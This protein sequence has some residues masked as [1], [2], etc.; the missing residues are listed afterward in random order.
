MFGVGLGLAL[1]LLLEWRDTSLKTDEDVK[2]AL[3]LPVLALIPVMRTQAD[4]RRAR[5]KRWAVG[6]ATATGLVGVGVLVSSS[7]AADRDV[8]RLLRPS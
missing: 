6:L 5:L 2:V 4:E 3:A 7:C 1:V 8:Y